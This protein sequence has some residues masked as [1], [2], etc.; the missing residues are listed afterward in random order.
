M[1]RVIIGA[2]ILIVMVALAIVQFIAHA[3]MGMNGMQLAASLLWFCV[4]VGMG[5]FVCYIIC[6]GGER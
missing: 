3:R 4:L 6:K 1:K 5:A 2:I